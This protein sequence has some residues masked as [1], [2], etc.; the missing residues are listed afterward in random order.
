MLFFI[1]LLQKILQSTETAVHSLIDYIDSKIEVAE[2]DSRSNNL[3]RRA[4]SWHLS[5]FNFY[6]RIFQPLIE[7]RPDVVPLD[8]KEE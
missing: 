8:P 1:Y 6:D 5:L 7:L 4:I 2:S 3:L